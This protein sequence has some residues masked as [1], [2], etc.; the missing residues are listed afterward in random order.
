[1]K[2][3]EIFETPEASG[4]DRVQAIAQERARLR[5]EV[6]KIATGVDQQGKQWIEL[7]DLLALL[8]D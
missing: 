1:M 8:R 2:P 5:E 4:F 3:S 7:P 6:V